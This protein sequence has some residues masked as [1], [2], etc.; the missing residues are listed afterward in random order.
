MLTYR[1]NFPKA[2]QATAVVLRE[3][4]SQM[5]F[6]R[7]LKLLYIA[8][9]EL[10]A[11]IGRTLT[12]DRAEALERGP[13]LT[14]VYDLVKGR[15]PDAEQA[16]WSAAIRKA[17]GSVA[18]TKAVPTGKLTKAEEEKLHVVCERF[19][20][21]STPD[22]IELT[23]KFAEW[24]EAYEAGPSSPINWEVALSSQG[25]GDLVPE[26]HRVQEDRER[27]EAVFKE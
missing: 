7:L 4:R 5:D 21:T 8:D 24:V 20:N 2:F 22:L 25:L 23:H 10:L 11:E 1:F 12:G 9:R 16:Q 3:H 17:D 13:V 19:R 18:L 27:A 15:G 14:T 6:V 26:V